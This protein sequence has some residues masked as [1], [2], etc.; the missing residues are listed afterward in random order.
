MSTVAPVCHFA[1]GARDK[2]LHG[3]RLPGRYT[4]TGAK[5]T[6]S[7][8][9]KLAKNIA[10]EIDESCVVA[11]GYGMVSLLSPRPADCGLPVCV[12]PGERW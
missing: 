1:Q 4:S 10:Q 11:V 7:A 6:I 8:T 9:M 12:S 2:K 3:D 5:D